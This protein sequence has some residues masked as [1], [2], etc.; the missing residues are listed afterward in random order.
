MADCGPFLQ[1][2]FKYAVDKR[3]VVH[4]KSGICFLEAVTEKHLV[5]QAVNEAREAREKGPAILWL[6]RQNKSCTDLAG[7]LQVVK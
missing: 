3:L 7:K 5:K 4:S 1:H 2:F 6:Q